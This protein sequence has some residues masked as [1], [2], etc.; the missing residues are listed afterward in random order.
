MNYFDNL[1]KENGTVLSQ[2]IKQQIYK[3]KVDWSFLWFEYIN[4]HSEKPWSYTVLRNNPNATR[5]LIQ[6]YPILLQKFSESFLN[7]NFNWKLIESIPET[8]V[9][10]I[11]VDE[12]YRILSGN[13]SL[14]LD[15]VHQYPLKQWDY[16]RLTENSNFTFHELKNDSNWKKYKENISSN[17]TVTWQNVIDNQTID[18]NYSQLSRNANINWDIIQANPQI[19]WDYYAFSQNPNITWDIVTNNPQLEFDYFSLCYNSSINW[20]TIEQNSDKLNDY[21][22]ISLNPNITWDIIDANPNKEWNYY[23]LSSNTFTFM[24]EIYLNKIMLQS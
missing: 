20:E 1:S 22:P 2:K 5:E 4:N 15:I 13:P 9:D 10:S 23:S 17:P 12:N 11:C 18:W 19:K 16:A 21:Y 14:S 8:N 6:A 24:Y 7:P 3:I